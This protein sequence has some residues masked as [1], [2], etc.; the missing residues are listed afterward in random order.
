MKKFKFTLIELL[1]VVAIIAILA[2]VLLPAL[3]AARNRARA[4]SCLSAQKQSGTALALM[5]NDLGQIINGKGTIHWG[6]LLKG[7]V[8]SRPYREAR[9]RLYTDR[10]T[11]PSSTV[12][13]ADTATTNQECND[14]SK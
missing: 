14:Y 5:Q 8:S 7:P 6:A 1:V 13:L 9:S 2:R 12:I 10:W 4:I 3:G 11:S